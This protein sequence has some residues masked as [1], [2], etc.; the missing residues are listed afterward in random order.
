ME[1]RKF[2]FLMQDEHF[3]AEPD[4]ARFE[5]PFVESHI[6]SVRTMAEAKEILRRLP[7]MGFGCVELCS[8][9]DAEMCKELYEMV[10]G[11]MIIGH[12]EFPPEHMGRLMEF[13][14]D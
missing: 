13:W 6:F 14:S 12:V 10:D 11:R 8:S 7:D 4:Y 3:N 5:C 2:A 9:F 1:K